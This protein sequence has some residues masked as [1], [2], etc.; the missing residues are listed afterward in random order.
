MYEGITG[1]RM[2]TEE[3]MPSLAAWMG[4]FLGSPA[5]RGH[6]PPLEKLQPRC[7]AMRQAFLKS[8]RGVEQQ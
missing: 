6:L 8:K 5:V 1:V 2:V 7:Q 3:K 4:K